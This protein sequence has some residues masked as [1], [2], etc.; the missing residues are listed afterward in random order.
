MLKAVLIENFQ[1]HKKTRMEFTPGVNVILG[2]S[3]AGKSAIFR[4][5]N[6]VLTN[7]PL[8]DSFRSEWGGDTRVALYFADGNVVE[9]IRS[10]TQN[11]YRVNG[12]PLRAFGSEVPEQVQE[13]LRLDR[14][15]VR[16]QFDPYFL[17]S[18]TPGEAAK[19]LNKAA[20]IDEIDLVTS[21]LR[22][23]Y[24]QLNSKISHQ[25]EEL[26]GMREEIKKFANL[27][28]IE[29]EVGELEEIAGEIQKREELLNTLCQTAQRYNRIKREIEQEV[30]LDEVE[31][32]VTKVEKRFR[33]F[34]ERMEYYTKLKSLRDKIV[35]TRHEL[36]TAERE[37]QNL[38]EKFLELAPETCPLC[39]SEV[40]WDV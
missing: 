4:A 28:K 32:E 36:R 39:G 26:E 13:V 16:G 33:K 35:S 25:E 11:E 1:S 12:E 40:E 21:E 6:W 9:R 10:A 37:V 29:E 17:L 7:R 27:P 22:R 15:N 8:G 19:I 23:G 30:Y 24:N 5:I 20:S 2:G 18:E 31:E 38:Q 14:A 3:D 34:Q